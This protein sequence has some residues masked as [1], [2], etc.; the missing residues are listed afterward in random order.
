MVSIETS[1]I[2]QLTERLFHQ[3]GL[4]NFSTNYWALTTDARN[5]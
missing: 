2:P 4:F 3:S 1:Q 5:I